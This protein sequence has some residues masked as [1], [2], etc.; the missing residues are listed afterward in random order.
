MVLCVLGP[1]ELFLSGC[2]LRF[3]VWQQRATKPCAPH[4][5]HTLFV[6]MVWDY[7]STVLGDI[8]E[9]FVI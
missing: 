4:K 7:P 6:D 2:P 8:A 3:F 1:Q 9:A 5:G